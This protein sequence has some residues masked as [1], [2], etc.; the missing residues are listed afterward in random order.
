MLA[1]SVMA[2][3]RRLA[4][5]NLPDRKDPP[6][7]TLLILPREDGRYETSYWA[8]EELAAARRRLEGL[9]FVSS[10]ERGGYETAEAQVGGLNV[11]GERSPCTRFGCRRARSSTGLLSL[12]GP[13]G[14]S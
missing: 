10:P 2:A 6:G 7:R 4:A 13:R 12:P 1:T 9:T 11:G 5:Q 14:T 3:V 8:P